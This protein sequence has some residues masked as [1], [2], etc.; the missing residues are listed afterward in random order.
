MSILSAVFQAIVQGLTEFLP[1]SSSGHLAL[2]QYF[3]GVEAENATFLSAV[4]HLGTL[5][6]VFIA[7]RKTIINLIFEFGYLI[8][9]IFKGKFRAKTMN[10]Y[11]RMII[12]LITATL[13]LLVI[14][15]FKDGYDSLIRRGGLAFTGLCFI[16]TSVV[17]YISDR[18]SRGTKTIKTMRYRDAI[19]IGIAQGIA[20]LPGISRS[21]STVAAS[22]IFG[23]SKKSAVQFSFILGIPAILGGGILELTDVIGTGVKLEILPILIGFVVSAITGLFAIKMI[24]W[25]IKTDK[26]KIFAYYTM[27]IGAVTIGISIFDMIYRK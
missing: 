18:C 4:M 16:I 14:L 22:M 9:D 3:L 25:L 21:G 15:P 11:R 10:Q 20:V 1:V 8:V 5:V 6:A 17:L 23:L 7:F 19:A 27:A 2:I 26:F 13:P 12:L 24:S